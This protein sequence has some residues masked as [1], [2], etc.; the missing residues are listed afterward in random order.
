[1]MTTADVEIVKDGV[2]LSQDGKKLMV[3]N[4]SQPNIEFSVV[5]L[6]PAP[7]EL[8]R[9]I[10]NLKR[11]ELR[12]PAWTLENGKGTIKIRLSSE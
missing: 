5:S 4:L 12:V 3:E 11:L 10:E 9:Q 6:D 8:D 1:M 2:V 7:M